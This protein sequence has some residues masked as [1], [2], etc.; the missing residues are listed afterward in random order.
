[1]HRLRDGLLYV[2]A[3]YTPQHPAPL[4][5]MLHGA[6][7][8]ARQGVGLVREYADAAGL[9]VLAPKARDATWDVIA[10]DQF[11]PD[12]AVIDAL[13]TEVFASCVVDASRIAVGGFSDGASYAL[14]LGVMN[15]E[16]FTHVVAFSPGFVAPLSLQGRPRLFVS[17]GTHDRVLPIDRCGRR[18][19]ASLTQAGYDV[20][21]REFDGPHTVPRDIA[22]DAVVW[23]TGIRPAI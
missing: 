5:V 16:L 4:A 17:H 7:G 19:Q 13:L 3:G 22:H 9:I 2:P 11:G 6:G 1:M 14:S 20:T 15:G 23:F 18:V 8:D 21:W 10:K 12:V